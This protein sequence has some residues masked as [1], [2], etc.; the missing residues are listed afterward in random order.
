M[1]L[2]RAISL[3]LAIG[4]VSGAVAATVETVDGHRFAGVIRFAGDGVICSS[5]DNKPQ[6]I[7]FADLLRLNTVATAL[8]ATPVP[9]K[10]GGFPEP[11]RASDL[12]PV[13]IQGKS[14][15]TNGVFTAEIAMPGSPF[16]SRGSHFIHQSFTG[17]GEAVVR[18]D[19]FETSKQGK[20]TK[21]GA[22][23]LMRSGLGPLD[24]KVLLRVD[25]NG[26]PAMRSYATGGGSTRTGEKMSFPCWLKLAREGDNFNGYYSQDGQTWLAIRRATGRIRVPLPGRFEI[27]LVVDA[28]SSQ[29]VSAQ[30]SHFR[31]GAVSQS[32]G[33]L[34]LA[35]PRVF[36]RDG[37]SASAAS[38]LLDTLGATLTEGAQTLTVREA[39]LAQVHYR[40]VPQLQHAD[41]A[42]PGVM[43]RKGDFIDGEFK[44]I[45]AGKVKVSSVLFGLRSYSLA[46]EVAVI[47]FRRAAPA[48][49]FEVRLRDRSVFT[50][51]ALAV[52]EGELVAT[53]PLAG[54]WRVP[55]VEV[56]EVVQP[57]RLAR[58]A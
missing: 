37:T 8:S 3:C 39:D 35:R 13:A 15:Y 6:F 44:G 18:V 48:A 29:S 41:L 34:A 55:L 32:P 22:G 27:G 58:A 53:L 23:L 10:E 45:V 47:V 14:A 30:F 43:L 9:V 25:A 33:E 57:Q 42:R 1:M 19:S 28:V 4:C 11:W 51:P 50:A 5:A 38:L 49:P 36:L 21:V 40:H 52:K 20:E 7:A 17:D 31:L 16:G 12:E 56:D 26:I 2:K 24:Y 46:D 54:V